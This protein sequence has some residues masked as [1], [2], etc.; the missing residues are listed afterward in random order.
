[1]LSFVILSSAMKLNLNDLGAIEQIVCA[2][3][4]RFIGTYFSTFTAH[5]LRLRGY[6]PFENI[7]KDEHLYW[8]RV[9]SEKQRVC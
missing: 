2:H 4:R 1:M 9:Q 6:L 7:E 3:G 8:D 5:I